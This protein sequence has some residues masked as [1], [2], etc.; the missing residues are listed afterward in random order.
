VGIAILMLVNPTFAHAV[1]FPNY[2]PVQYRDFLKH[3]ADHRTLPERM[4]NIAGLT[5]NEYG[6]SLQGCLGIHL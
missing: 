4:L 5:S 1:N 2:L 3:F 6:L